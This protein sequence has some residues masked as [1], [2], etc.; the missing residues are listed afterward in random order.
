MAMDTWSEPFANPPL[1]YYEGVAHPI[2]ALE[3]IAEL[4]M[5][6]FKAGEIEVRWKEEA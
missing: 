3:R 6:R 5:T 4:I 2:D 1:V